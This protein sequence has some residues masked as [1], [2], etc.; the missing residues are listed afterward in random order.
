MYIAII[1][2]PFRHKYSLLHSKDKAES[3]GQ[4]K[5]LTGRRYLNPLTSSR[6]YR[7][8]SLLCPL[9][10]DPWTTTVMLQ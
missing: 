9:P 2:N 5:N 1:I 4:S 7:A 3:Y 8:L 6:L 10:I